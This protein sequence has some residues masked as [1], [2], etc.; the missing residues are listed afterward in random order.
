[1]SGDDKRKCEE[2]EEQQCWAHGARILLRR[3]RGWEVGGMAN[4]RNSARGFDV[5]VV[6]TAEILRRPSDGSG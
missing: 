5:E 1:L 4:G 2:R 3:G 6:V